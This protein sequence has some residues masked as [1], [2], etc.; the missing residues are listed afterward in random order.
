MPSAHP[1]DKPIR[2]E[3]GFTTTEL[4]AA[5]AVFLVLCA[6]CVK[7]LGGVIKRIRLQNAA[8]GMKHFVMNARVRSVSNPDR[9]CGVVFRLHPGSN[10]DDTLFAFLEKSPPDM[11][12]VAGQDELYLAPYVIPRKQGITAA[13]PAGFPTELVF[14]G[15]GSASASA[16]VALSLGPFRDTVD[17]LASTGRVRVIR[18]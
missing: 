15:D 1:A 7:P 6:V 10:M 14:R 4:L 16:K 11:H 2:G 3:A 12:Y 17:V 5:A 8:D 18:K 9:R 13:V